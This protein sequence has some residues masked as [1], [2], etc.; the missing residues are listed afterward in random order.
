MTAV[1]SEAPPKPLRTIEN[2]RTIDEA[3]EGRCQRGDVVEEHWSKGLF[4]G[5]IAPNLPLIWWDGIAI[6]NERY[7]GTCETFDYRKNRI[8]QYGDAGQRTNG[9]GSKLRRAIGA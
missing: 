8:R 4:V 1:L 6:N 3:R 2:P 7:L 5:M 9:R